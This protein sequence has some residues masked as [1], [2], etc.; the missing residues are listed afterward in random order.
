M[1]EPELFIHAGAHRTGTSSF[2]MCLHENRDRLEAGG[3]A[4]AYPGRDGIPSGNLALR[5]P[6]GN[7]ADIAQAREKVTKTLAAHSADKSLILSEENIL[8]RMFH[9][10]QGQ[11]YPHAE[12]RCETL[13]L[14]WPGKIAHVMLVV[15][16]YHELFVSAFRKRAEDNAMPDFDSVR[17]AY[18][19]IDRGW[20]EVIAI[21]R[22]VLKPARLSVVPFAARGTSTELL[23]RLVPGL[24]PA[25][26]TE[27]RRVVNKSATDA[28][29]FALQAK[30]RA[31][32]TLTR[33]AWKTIIQDHRTD[34][35]PRGFAAFA[36]AEVAALSAR[37][38]SDL[39]QIEWM[40][41]VTFG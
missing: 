27:P 31:G 33:A 2:Q 17:D 16:P 11:F 13:R 38:A 20:P 25:A 9:F 40:P 5:L 35:E 39:K 12:L 18:L 19:S 37:Y 7:T 3:W 26:L 28:A 24:D 29:L 23:G 15:R 14:A 41:K 10:M 22:D 6:A 8:G 21:L 30:Y 1:A 36:P 4:M 32:E 34:A